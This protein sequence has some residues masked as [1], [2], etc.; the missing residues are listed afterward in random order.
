MFFH[1]MNL[2][3]ISAGVD[4]RRLS[5]N[6]LLAA[7]KFP[8]R[9]LEAF[10]FRPIARVRGDECLQGDN[11][12]NLSSREPYCGNYVF[13]SGTKIELRMYLAN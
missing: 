10:R 7:C 9:A 1:P 6:E 4:F 8:I 12:C 5:G 13:I 2:I 11:Q 3:L